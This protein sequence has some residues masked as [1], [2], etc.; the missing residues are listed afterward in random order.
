MALA[1]GTNSGFVSTAPTSDPGGLGQFW[2]NYAH[3]TKD[4][5]PSTAG[6]IT[7]IGWYSRDISEEANFEVGLYAAD[8][9]YVPGEA[10][11][12]IHSSRTHA[13][14]TTAGWKTATVNWTIS[15]DTAYWLGVQVDDT[16]TATIGIS[17][18]TDGSGFDRRSGQTTLPEP[19]GGATISDTDGMEAI[20]AVWT[21]S[22]SANESS[23]FF[24]FI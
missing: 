6:K 15:P 5:S 21:T 24:N 11:T 16:T 10:G 17:S 19:F 18:L 2:D 13:K 20:Y 8:G 4:T 22:D 1:L 14:G 23:N 3:V 9:A 12:L 7:E